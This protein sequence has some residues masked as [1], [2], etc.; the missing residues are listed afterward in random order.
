MSVRVFILEARE[1]KRLQE[2]LQAIENKTQV[3]RK[4]PEWSR[5]EAC[6]IGG[7][8]LM[9]A[10]LMDDE[11]QLRRPGELTGRGEAVWTRGRTMTDEAS[12][13]WGFKGI[14]DMLIVGS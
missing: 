10:R 8:Y 13:I 5:C 14:L 7:M 12:S 3:V 6:R 2:K 4:E 1:V 11:K 9:K